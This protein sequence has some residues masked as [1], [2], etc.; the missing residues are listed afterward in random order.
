[1]KS[2]QI[3]SNKSIKETTFNKIAL[4]YITKLVT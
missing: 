1:M 3:K 4:K 2:N